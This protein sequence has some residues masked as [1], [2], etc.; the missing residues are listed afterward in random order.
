MKSI[1]ACRYELLLTSALSGSLLLAGAAAA[2]TSSSQPPSSPSGSTQAASPAQF[3]NV[4]EVVVTAQ[5]RTQLLRDVPMSVMVVNTQVLRQNQVRG[6]DDLLGVVPGVTIEHSSGQQR[7][8]IDGIA[9]IFG[10]ASTV[11]VYVNDASATVG[12]AQQL[13]IATMDLSRVEVLRGPQGTLYGDGSLGGTIRFITNSPDLN[14]YQFVADVGASGTIGSSDPSENFAPV[15]NVP[16][17]DGQLAVRVAALFDH[18]GG[19]VDDPTNDL[20]NINYNNRVD[21][22]TEL[23]WRPNDKLKVQAMVIDHRGY[24]S[25]DVGFI[26]SHTYVPIPPINGPTYL[27]DNYDLYNLNASYDL[28]FATLHSST[29]YYNYSLRQALEETN[30]T[31][32]P[33]TGPNAV[34]PLGVVLNPAIGFDTDFNEEVRL[35]SNPGSPLVW[36]VGYFFERQ[37]VYSNDEN[38]YLGSEP[39]Q[40]PN[41]GPIP[42]ALFNFFSTNKLESS[43][44]FGN[45]SYKFFNRLTLGVGLRYY[46]DTQTNLSGFDDLAFLNVYQKGHD[47]SLDPRFDA[48]FAVTGDLNVYASAAKGFRSGGFNPGN[49][50]PEPAYNPEENWRYEAGAKGAFFNGRL[51]ANLAGF[52]TTYSNYIVLG[53]VDVPGLGAQDIFTN[54]GD[55]DIEGLEWDI[56]W[57]PNADWRLS[58]NGE[59][60]HSAYTKVLAGTEHH[61]GDPVDMVSPVQATASVQRNFEVKRLPAYVMVTVKSQA[62]ETYINRNANGLGNSNWYIGKSSQLTVLD[63]RAQVQV[64]DHVA[65]GVYANNLLNDQGAL[66][67]LRPE[68]VVDY[69]RPTTIGVDAH[70]SY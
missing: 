32:G 26:N 59:Y 36:D 50:V 70:I 25:N 22:R 12:A 68:M 62:P 7:V 35:N 4:G 17:I 42:L 11:G 38:Y 56:N 24:G 30:P 58:F 55:A 16:L 43:S 31:T 6:L 67:P 33:L 44:Y 28:G 21:V 61:V 66:N 69:E 34:P 5:K 60:L 1:F 8:A 63:L 10:S 3:N 53:F 29:T 37:K 57:V 40:P 13:N 2:Q 64:N 15:V 46:G 14:N 19:W 27:T 52:Y 65:I 41:Y 49:G 51:T 9:N 45:I 18:E 47:H 39:G 54:G 23:L 48:T 20:K